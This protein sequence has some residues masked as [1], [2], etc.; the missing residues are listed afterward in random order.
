MPSHFRAVGAMGVP[1]LAPRA[2]LT[3][4]RALYSLPATNHRRLRSLA[5]N[6]AHPRPIQSANR[7]K[8]TWQTTRTYS[9]G[10]VPRKS[11]RI[12]TTFRWLWRLTYLSALGTVGYVC[13]TVYL[14]R[15]PAPQT[16]PDPTKKTLVV[17][18]QSRYSEMVDA[19]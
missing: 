12:R 14:D 18:G 4:C 10:A 15:H 9:D 5:T 7:P 19:H 8:A 17:L 6:P 1:G 11:G 2:A 16:I 13:Y 3:T